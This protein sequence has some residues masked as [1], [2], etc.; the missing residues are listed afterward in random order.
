MDHLFLKNKGKP[1][2][3]TVFEFIFGVIE[4]ITRTRITKKIRI[5]GLKNRIFLLSSKILQLDQIEN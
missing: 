3:Q 4:M 2:F 1:T 5:K